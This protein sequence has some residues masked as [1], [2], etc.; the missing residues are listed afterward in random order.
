MRIRSVVRVNRHGMARGAEFAFR[1]GFEIG[2]IAS[3]GGGDRQWS[4]AD[5]EPQ[6]DDAREWRSSH[7]KDDENGGREKRHK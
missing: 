2:H 7:E 6:F 1:G 3:H 5:E 4:E